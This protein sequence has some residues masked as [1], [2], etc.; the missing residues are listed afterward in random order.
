MNE[1][2]YAERPAVYDVL[3]A[4]KEYD[5]EVAWVLDRFEERGNG[6]DRALVVGCGT[7]E[8]ARRLVDRGFDV[9]GVDRY[10]AMV[11]RARTK[12]DAEFRV[13]RLPD[14]NVEGVY[15]LV[16]APFTVANHLP[17]ADFGASLRAMAER[18]A[19]SEGR[20][21][22]GDRAQSGD[23]GVLVVDT[24][25]VPDEETPPRLYS[26]EGPDGEYARL[27]QTHSVGD[28]RRRW[29]SLVFGPDGDFFVDTHDLWNY[30]EAFVTGAFS[31]AGLDVTV[32]DWYGSNE[33][34]D[35][36]V[37]VGQRR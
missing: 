1:A 18:V 8:H 33:S 34:V 37:F 19:D 14:L 16:W 15:D 20:S 25:S 3:Y 28:R 12:S 17:P 10:E 2:L 26:Y 22:S 30:G 7:G 11:E 24:M 6:G 21:R 9:T 32:H 5:R 31:G 36:S 29:D 35:G 27:V 23:R 4:D 13:G